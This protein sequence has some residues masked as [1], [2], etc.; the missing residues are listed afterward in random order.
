MPT[1]FDEANKSER[2]VMIAH[3][4][5]KFLEPPPPDRKFNP[6]TGDYVSPTG[7]WCNDGEFY[8]SGRYKKDT[9]GKTR[10]ERPDVKCEACAMGMLLIAHTLRYNEVSADKIYR[11]NGTDCRDILSAH[12]DQETLMLIEAA[13]EQNYEFATSYDSEFDDDNPAVKAEE[14]GERYSKNDERL[15]AIMRNVIENNGVF[16]P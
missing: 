3:D 5:L 1:I 10:L 6:A 8:G 9:D 16:V 12:F 2:A 11:A 4:V 15:T 13:F 7:N 14:F